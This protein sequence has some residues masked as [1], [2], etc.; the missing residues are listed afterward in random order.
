MYFSYILN[1]PFDSDDQNGIVYVWMGGRCDSE[2]A[3][4]SEEVAEDMFG[5]SL[6]YYSS[7]ICSAVYMLINTTCMPT[8]F[9]IEYGF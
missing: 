3:R 6:I 4:L 8:S 7:I 2:E 9:Q 1:V 5:V